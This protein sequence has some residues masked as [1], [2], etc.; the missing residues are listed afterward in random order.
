MLTC[1]LAPFEDPPPDMRQLVSDMTARINGEEA[2]MKLE[3]TPYE[4]RSTHQKRFLTK[5]SYDIET[6]INQWKEWVQWRHG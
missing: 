1:N 6:S 5:N 3:A 2:L 4:R